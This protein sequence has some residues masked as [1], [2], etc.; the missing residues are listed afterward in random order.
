MLDVP[1]A[2]LAEQVELALETFPD[3]LSVAPVW[4]PSSRTL[5][6]GA[7]VWSLDQRTGGRKGKVVS[8]SRRPEGAVIL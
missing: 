3:A 4:K 2:R 7:L 8:L 1:Y 6:V 5:D